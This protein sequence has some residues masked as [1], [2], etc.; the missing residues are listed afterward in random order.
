MAYNK[1]TNFVSRYQIPFT[2]VLD[3]GLEE[4]RGL[5]R[6]VVFSQSLPNGKSILSKMQ[7][8]KVNGK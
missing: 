2:T 4:A 6:S 1:L 7:R 3:L 8:L 5:A